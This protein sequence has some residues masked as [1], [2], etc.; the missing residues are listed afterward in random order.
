MK[1]ILPILKILGW[2]GYALA[3][4]LAIAVFFTKADVWWEYALIVCFWVF[5]PIVKAYLVYT[6]LGF[7]NLYT[8]LVVFSLII[9]CIVEWLIICQKELT[10]QKE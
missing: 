10:K 3:A 2:G 8:M 6:E 7:F 1:F 5:L 9:S 4:I